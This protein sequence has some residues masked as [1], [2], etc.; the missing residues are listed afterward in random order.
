MDARLKK[1]VTRNSK[2]KAEFSPKSKEYF[3]PR[4]SKQTYRRHVLIADA[5]PRI[6]EGRGLVHKKAI[7]KIV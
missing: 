5:Q 1:K 7:L 2:P 3:F 6:F 4:A